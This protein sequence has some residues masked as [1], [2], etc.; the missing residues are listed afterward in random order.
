MTTTLPWH[1]HQWTQILQHYQQDRLPHAL[2]F[3]GPVGM[4]KR[5][6]AQQAAEILLCHHPILPSENEILSQI[7]PCGHCKSC[8]LIS[9]GNHPD[10]KQIEPVETGKQ[11]KIEQIRDLIEF[12]NLTP[13]YESYQIVII[14]PAEAMNRNAANSLLK[15][16]EE[17]PS[18]T[19]IF[20][21]SHQPMA[22]MA[23]VR[24]RCQRINFT[25][26]ESSLVH[27]WLQNQ[28]PNQ[29][30]IELLL[31]L[32]AQAPLAALA[33]VKEEDLIKRQTLLNSLAKLPI[34]QENP[35]KIA[36]MW[37]KLEAEKVLS[38]MLSWT[39]DLIRY[40]MTQ[41]THYIVNQDF[42]ESVQQ[43]SKQLTLEGLF[44]MLDLEKEVHRLIAGTTTHI[45]P[46]GLLESL[47]IEWV[48]LSKKSRRV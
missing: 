10:L 12:C 41:Q 17:P 31:N 2:L 11:I 15:L 42:K 40:T 36:E 13:T 25:Y 33:L 8:H 46:Q 30:N 1:Q 18:K 5:H 35:V 24:S 4:G 44:A 48:K 6:F 3:C 28:L 37:S 27:N 45:K 19:L 23:T 9:V 34:Q 39:M 29:Q 20:L 43:L 26:P 22:L 47:A 16:L 14:T 38:W 21:I 7:R 32:S